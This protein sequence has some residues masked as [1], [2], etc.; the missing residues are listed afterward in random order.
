MSNK[1]NN[2]NIINMTLCAFEIS[3][4]IISINFMNDYI[5]FIKGNKNIFKI[6]NTHLTFKSINLLPYNI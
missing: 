5:I 2:I 4:G 1:N 3:E 6:I